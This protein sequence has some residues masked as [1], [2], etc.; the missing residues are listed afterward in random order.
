MIHVFRNSSDLHNSAILDG[1]FRLRKKAFSDRLQWDVETDGEWEKDRF[2]ELDPVYLVSVD[3][4][5]T[6]VRGCLRL[7]PTTGPNMLRDVFHELLPLGEVVESALIWESSRFCVDHEIP[8][9]RGHNGIRY[10]TGEL[11]AGAIDVGLRSGLRFIVSVFDARMLRIL[12]ACQCPAEVIGGPKQ[13]G[14]C[15]TY[16]GLFEVS[17]GVLSNISTAFGFR[18][19]VLNNR[20]PISIAA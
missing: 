4:T 6:Q 1:V 20:V 5:G 15:R 7:L 17:E 3:D 12:R 9:V 18:D 11:V 16:A 19:S 10:V 14:V 2:D 8:D 13:I